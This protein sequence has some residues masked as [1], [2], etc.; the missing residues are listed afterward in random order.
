MHEILGRPGRQIVHHL[1]AAGNDARCNDVADR[2]ARLL[3]VVERRHD[4]LGGNRFGQQ[5]DGDL[6]DN[7]EHALRP[8]QQRQQVVSRGVQ[9]VRPDGDQVAFDVDH[10]QLQDIVDRQ[11]ILQAV[12]TTGVLGNITADAAGNL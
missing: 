2:V 4:E 11:P 5:P 3:D 9:A 1:E 8:G 7:A 10:L 6:H 12:Q